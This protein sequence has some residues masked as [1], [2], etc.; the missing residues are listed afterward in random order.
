VWVVCD[1]YENELAS[2]KVGDQADITLSAYP[3]KVL[4]GT[5]SNIG[6]TLDPSIRT[7][8]VRIEVPNP[9]LMRLGMFVTATLRGKIDLVETAVPA[10]AILHLHDRDYVYVPAPRNQFRRVEVVSG[11]TL[12]DNSQE[13]RSGL[14]Q[15]QQVVS[16][17]L[18]MQHTIEQ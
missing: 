1:V 4:K 16:N 6:A 17:A 13:I 12:A 18:A 7:G 10:S 9:G 11:E 14:K 15:G 8:K 2:V 3:G 5:V